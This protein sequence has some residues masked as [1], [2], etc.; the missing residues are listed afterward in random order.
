MPWMQGVTQQSGVTVQ[1]LPGKPH[2]VFV[3][4]LIVVVVMVVLVLGG[5]DSGA[6]SIFRTS[7]WRKRVPNWSVKETLPSPDVRHFTL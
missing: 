6:Q 7:G 2:P 4:V 1:V 3:V 5:A